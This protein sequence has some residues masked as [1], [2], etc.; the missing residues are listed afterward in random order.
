M[1]GL[2][3]EM[4]GTDAGY[5]FIDSQL[6]NNGVYP[7]EGRDDKMEWPFWKYEKG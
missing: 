1:E 2:R 5:Y 3:M 7:L 6:G 4:V